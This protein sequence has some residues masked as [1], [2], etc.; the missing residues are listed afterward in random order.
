M[1]ELTKKYFSKIQKL[2]LEK[3][4]FEKEYDFKIKK[5][6]NANVLFNRFVLNCS[7]K[8]YLPPAMEGLSLW[9]KIK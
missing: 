2:K 7:A 6:A 8:R 5:G 4:K 3:L 1:T 9:K